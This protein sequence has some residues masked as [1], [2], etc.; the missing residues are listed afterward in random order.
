MPENAYPPSF[1]PKV[2]AD[3]AYDHWLTTEFDRKVLVVVRTLT[4]L[5]RL[6]DVVSL[7][8]SDRRIQLVFTHDERRPGILSAGV[9]EALR[10]L[11]PP[12]IGWG[13]ATATRFDL[14]LAA[15]ENDVLTELDAPILL[16]PHG[17]GYQK[18]YPGSR[19]TSGLD[20]EKLVHNG[21][22]VPAAI[23][24]SHESQRAQLTRSCPPAAE[25]AVVIGDPCLDRMVMSRHR[26]SRY[27]KA[28]DAGGRTVVTL[29]STW[30]KHSLF[31][32]RPELPVELLGCLPFDDYRVV[33]TL[34]PGVWAAHGPWQVR[35]WLR[36]AIAAG[37]ALVPPDHG[38]QAAVLAADCVLSDEGS[39]ALYAA[40]VDKPV[41][42]TTPGSPTTVADSPLAAL[43]RSVPK[44]GTEFGLRDQ[45]DG[46][47]AR[48]RPGSHAPIIQEAVEDP[49]APLL[50]GLLYALLGLNPPDDP[51]FPPVA[52][53]EPLTSP[54]AA[55]VAGV[56]A[57]GELVRFPLVAEKAPDL[58]YRHVLAHAD[59]AELRELDAATVVYADEPGRL[60]DLLAH[61]PAARLA[62]A[63]TDGG[64]LVRDST[65]ETHA[66]TADVDPVLLAAFAYV[67]LATSRPLTGDLN[68]AAVSALRRR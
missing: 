67:R 17:I 57:S 29:A 52:D 24:L 5:T 46:A 50:A 60:D 22:V 44:L 40:A 66:L 2:P 26:V 18:Y 36:P 63:P 53:P 48:H 3:P 11:G 14:A 15:S 42:L 23:A 47:I 37:L 34:H 35:S 31:G 6:L 64:C 45:I 55:F 49:G 27:R 12:V 10:R 7:F 8:G 1:W 32:R 54:A 4:T 56:D 33:L 20:P 19:V 68:G 65:G 38:W 58:E 43:A 13:Q 21:E 25:R 51:V 28:L 61:W 30:G 41:L 16:V 9:P 39:A 62:A 59:N